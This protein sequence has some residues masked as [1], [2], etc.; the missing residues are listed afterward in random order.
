MRTG[1][2]VAAAG[3][4]GLGIGA[5]LAGVGAAMGARTGGPESGRGAAAESVL[6]AEVAE[7]RTPSVQYRF[8]NAES[9]LFR[10]DDGVADVEAGRPATPR[11]MYHAFSITKTL[12]AVA[13]LQLTEQ[14]LLR[15]DDPVADRLPG[16]PY[17]RDVTVRHLL[18]HSA[19]LA[20]PMPLR[21]IHLETEHSGFDRDA[22]FR[23]ILAR[24]HRLRTAPNDRFAYSNL[25]YV[26]LGQIVERVSGQ[27]YEDYV[28]A[29]ILRPLGLTDDDLGFTIDASHHA[30]GYQRRWSVGAAVLRLLL[31]TDKHVEPAAGRW[32]AFRPYYVNGAPYGGIMGTADGFM[33]Y[34][35]GLLDP[36][37]GLLS[38]ESLCVLF[39]ENVLSSG[40]ASG[41]SMAWFT[42]ALE[43][44]PYRAHAGGGGGYYAELRIYP[45]AGLGSVILLN[46]TGMRD[47]RFLDRVDR[48]L[49]GDGSA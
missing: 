8:F 16:V 30:R 29:R 32:Q 21:W 36:A 7:G 23:P 27:S 31:D 3:W 1:T 6:R 14:G 44:H 12:T 13:I 38:E 15:L 17:P 25:G 41:M 34:A 42:G 26:L 11:T 19:G 9:V 18:T 2:L 37:S 22:F 20:N 10:Y 48:H 43:G 5:L 24:H 39:T 35:Q 47:Q 40:R 49:V 46:R 33:R 4:S 45:E 28:Q